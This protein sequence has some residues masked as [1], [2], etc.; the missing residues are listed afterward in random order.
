MLKTVPSYVA[1]AALLTASFATQSQAQAIRSQRPV[2]NSNDLT[3]ATTSPAV[4]LAKRP[5]S[6]ILQRPDTSVITGANG[7]TMTVGQIRAQLNRPS[8]ITAAQINIGS[9]KLPAIGNR[10]LP[11]GQGR[12]YRNEIT[13]QVTLAQATDLSALV[14]GCEET[15]P[16]LQ[17]ANGELTP[18]GVVTI[19]GN[20]LGEARGEL[21]MYG[22]FSGGVYSLPIHH[23]GQRSI[24]TQIPAEIAGVG[25]I[26]VRFE[27]ITAA[28][29]TTTP[30]A[31]TF[32]PRMELVDV[33]AYWSGNCRPYSNEKARNICTAN[34][35]DHMYWE[36]TAFQILISDGITAERHGGS[37]WKITV[38]S[39]CALNV[40]WWNKGHG[41][42]KRFEG[43]EAGPAHESNVKLTTN[44]HKWLDVSMWGD[45]EY[46]A[47]SYSLGAN[48]YCPAGVSPQP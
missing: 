35:L 26:P 45:T 27:V 13:S 9:A 37:D 48:A 19:S 10:I 24:V 32:S 36:S 28:R 30:L 25:V 46:S 3:R 11:P 2:S 39:R 12:D 16:R 33:S 14:R 29:R 44:H 18:S 8:E 40:A 21:R 38:N 5:I 43:W 41:T 23:W 17:R 1:V 22:G 15:G 4:Q 42:I 6:E 31:A 20:C 7:A 47:L 34:S